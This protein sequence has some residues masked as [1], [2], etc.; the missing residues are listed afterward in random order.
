LTN[1]TLSHNRASASAGGGLYNASGGTSMLIFTT[2]ASNTATVVVPEGVG[3]HS[4]A[5]G[6]VYLQNTFVAHNGPVD[7]SPGI[8]SNGHNLDDGIS[9][10]FSASGDIS[11]TVPYLGPLMYDPDPWAGS[12]QGTWVHPLQD[13]SPAIDRGVCILGID[14]DQRGAERLKGDMCDIGAYEYEGERE[15]SLPL[16]LRDF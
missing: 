12:G 16:V 6:Q 14:T 10:G 4:A 9:C 8:T 5:G 1:V 11:N 2:V 7:C 3:I 13:G 15:V